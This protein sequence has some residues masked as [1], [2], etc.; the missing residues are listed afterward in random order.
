MIS[1]SGVYFVFLLTTT[2]AAV[3]ILVP[4]NSR[5]FKSLG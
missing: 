2:F 5:M 3:V 4:D 1:S